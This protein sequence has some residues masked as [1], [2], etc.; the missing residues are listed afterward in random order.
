VLQ[1]T[2]SLWFCLVML[3]M[4]SSSACVHYV[5]LVCNIDDYVYHCHILGRLFN[6]DMFAHNKSGAYVQ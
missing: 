6:V 4:A 5:L 3:L 1:L 2:V